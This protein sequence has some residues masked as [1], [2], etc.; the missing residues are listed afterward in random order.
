MTAGWLSDPQMLEVVKSFN[1]QGRVADP[2]EI[3]GL[4]MLLASP[5]AS[6]ITGAVISIDGGQTAH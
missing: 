2:E 5:M 3:A 4:V 6:F 1:A